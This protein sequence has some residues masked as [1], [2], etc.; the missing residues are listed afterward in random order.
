MTKCVMALD[1]GTTSTR[2]ILFGHD[3]RPIAS[4]QVEHRQIFPQTG[5]VEHDPMEIWANTRKVMGAALA[6]AGTAIKDVVSIGITQQRETTIVWD[7]TSGQ[8]VYNAIVWQD[9]R[10][11]SIIDKSIDEII[12]IMS[13]RRNNID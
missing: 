5:W 12:S 4:S 7:R 9:T 6:D 3:G 8:P 13:Y 11:K 1:Q 2:A 10:T